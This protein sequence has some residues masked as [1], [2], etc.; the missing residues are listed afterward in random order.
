MS[1]WKVGLE[2]ASLGFSLHLHPCSMSFTA[3]VLGYMQPRHMAHALSR[4][5]SAIDI[6]KMGL[7]LHLCIFRWVIKK[8]VLCDWFSLPH[9]FPLRKES[10]LRLLFGTNLVFQSPYGKGCI[11][12]AIAMPKTHSSWQALKAQ[13]L[14]PFLPNFFHSLRQNLAL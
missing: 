13:S 1:Y 4:S 6:P 2:H 14:L 9:S 3:L 8:N 11:I 7:W 10:D 12:Q 5:P